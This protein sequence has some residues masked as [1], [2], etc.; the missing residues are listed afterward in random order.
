MVGASDSPT[1]AAGVSTLAFSM[2]YS[3]LKNWQVSF[4]AT[5]LTNTKRAQYRYSEE[6]QQKLDVSGRV[7]YVNVKYRF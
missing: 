3:F 6:E 5:N 7:F 1:M 4:D 2:N